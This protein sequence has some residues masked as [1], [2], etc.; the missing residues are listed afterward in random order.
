[1]LKQFSTAKKTV[2]SKLVPKMAVFREYT[3]YEGL[4]IKYRH[5]DPEKALPYPERRLLTY[6]A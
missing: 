1:M 3:E 2:Q 4:N 6:F 5:C